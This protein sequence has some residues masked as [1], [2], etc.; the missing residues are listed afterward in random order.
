MPNRAWILAVEGAANATL[1]TPDFSTFLLAGCESGYEK[2]YVDVIPAVQE[3]VEPHNP[4]EIPVIYSSSGD[5]DADVY[6]MFENGYLP[7]GSVSFNGPIESQD[8]IIEQAKKVGADAVVASSEF[9]NSVTSSIPITTSTPV[10]TYHSGSATAYGSG[11]SAYGTY[12]GTSTTYVPST[13]YIPVTVNRYDQSA[14][15][16]ARMKPSCLGFWMAEI[17]TEERQKIGTNSGFKIAALRKDAPFYA[18]DIVPGD[19]V[20]EIDDAKVTLTTEF[21]FSSGQNINVTVFRNGTILQKAVTTGRCS[22]RRQR[23]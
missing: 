6:S 2:F 20:L 16:F 11:G 3:W 18:A 21:G 5:F 13:T 4:A 1:C 23:L 19:I 22:V 7:I 15:F 9:T 17:S 8:N 12:S 10:T 14:I